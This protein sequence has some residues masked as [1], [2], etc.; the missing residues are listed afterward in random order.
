MKKLLRDL[1]DYFGTGQLVFDTAGSLTK[2]HQPEFV[3]KSSLRARWVVD[4]ARDIERFHPK[5]KLT[6]RVRWQE[7]MGSELPMGQNLPPLF[8]VWTT[9]LV[10]LKNNSLFKDCIQVLRFAF[11]DRAAS[12]N[13]SEFTITSEQEERQSTSISELPEYA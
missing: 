8:G 3:K 2:K 9:A 1:V 7:Y 13:S 11:G 4:D 12:V 6:G 10:S 5:L